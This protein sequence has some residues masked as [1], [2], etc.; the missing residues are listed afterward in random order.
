MWD[1]WIICLKL[2]LCVRSSPFSWF[3]CSVVFP[4]VW[5]VPG[6]WTEL[7]SE[8]LNTDYRSEASAPSRFTTTSDQRSCQTVSASQLWCPPGRRCPPRT[9]SADMLSIVKWRPAPS[10]PGTT[11]I[12]RVNMYIA[13]TVWAFDVKGK[14]KKP[15]ACP[16]LSPERNV[17]LGNTLSFMCLWALRVVY[18]HREVLMNDSGS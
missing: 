17:Q 15:T 18:L 11:S 13:S 8:T 14:A 3:F 12:G 5:F 4:L 6:V 16:Q 1:N 10:S 7:R 9:H 2:T